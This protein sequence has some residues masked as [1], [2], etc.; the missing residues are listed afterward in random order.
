MLRP[1]GCRP[2]R[3]LLHPALRLPVR[4]VLLLLP[5]WA[6]AA[7]LSPEQAVEEVD[8]D[9]YTKVGQKQETLFGERRPFDVTPPRGRLAQELVDPE[10]GLVRPGSHLEVGLGDALDI[11]AQNSRDFQDAKED[12]FRSALSFLVEEHSFEGQPF[13]LLDGSAAKTAD[14]ESVS[15][16]G[17]FGVTKLLERGGSYVL[18]LGLDFLRFVS[19][20]TDEDL[21]SFLDLGITLPFLRNAGREIVVE[22]LRQ[23]DRN[24]LYALRTF[25]RF[26][27]TYGVRVISSYLRI[28]SEARRIENEEANV[29][30]LRRSRERIEAMVELEVVARIELDQARQQELRGENRLVVARQRFAS[31]LDS[32]KELMGLPVDL[33]VD[34]RLEDLEGLDELMA[35]DLELEATGM[36]KVALTSRLDFRNAVDTV[37]DAA[38]RV[39]VAENQL[40]PDLD[41]ELS[42]RVE[43]ENLKPL[44]YNTDNG[45][46]SGAIVLDPGL[47]RVNES[48]ALRSALLDLQETLRNQEAFRDSVVFEVQD[49]F[50]NLERTRA[51]YEI[52]KRAV[53]LAEIRVDSTRMSMEEGRAS[54]RDFL[55]A[56]EALIQSQ[57][58]LVDN[59]VEYR[60]AY[61]ELL[62]D[63][64]VLVVS[65]EGLEHDTSAELLRDS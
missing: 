43:S 6:A 38:R 54:T 51:S 64:G 8:E 29:A 35:E 22:N 57:N 60:I 58:D 19:S 65:S 30:S 37:A 61:L 11:A 4:A 44:K 21:N 10:T 36:V 62:R 25:E 55:E 3:P 24:V 56:Q 59:L 63:T 18:S 16:G 7:C 26:K 2:K 1:P 45:T 33:E 42:A 9:A 46:Y 5:L 41:L 50:R 32:F 53:E 39:R 48:V 49:A 31:S 40:L 27:Q 52:S 28:L 14:V 15:A 13:A 12:L 23:A 47:D 34:V 20:P 17:E